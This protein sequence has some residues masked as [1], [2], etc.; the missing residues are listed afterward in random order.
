VF[1]S[2]KSTNPGG[3]ESSCRD[4]R[5][6]RS[7]AVNGNDNCNGTKVGK[8]EL[9]KPDFRLTEELGKNMN[10]DASKLAK[11]PGNI[12]IIDVEYDAPKL[13]EQSA[14]FFKKLSKLKDNVQVKAS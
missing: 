4:N 7:F 11:F 8:F 13:K 3:R 6:L 1:S 2:R 9:K 12:L 14:D 10:V 5:S